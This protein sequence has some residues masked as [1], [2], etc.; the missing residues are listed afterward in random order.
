MAFDRDNLEFQVRFTN[1]TYG[2]KVQNLK[3]EEG[4]RQVPETLM[5]LHIN[6]AILELNIDIEAETNEQVSN[7]VK[8]SDEWL[9]P[10]D[11]LAIKDIIVFSDYEDTVD[12]QTQSALSQGVT[13]RK[14]VSY[15][16]LI[17]PRQPTEDFGINY[18]GTVFTDPTDG[19][20]SS[21]FLIRRDGDT[22]VKFN[23]AT[24][25][26]YYT[27]IHFVKLPD[28]LT[29]GSQNPGI[30]A[31]YQSLIVDRTVYRIA[32]QLGDTGRKLEAER[33]YEKGLQKKNKIILREVT[34]DR[35]I[36]SQNYL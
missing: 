12:D 29:T 34:P 16:A 18:T 11:M 20:P 3:T 28:T 36:L 17:S 32:K 35:L 14:A 4:K 23:R 26:A 15:A 13:L 21:Y 31:T 9:L 33:D 7:T 27:E 19:I 10:T 8:D 25:H 22:L 30:A 5:N 24:D 1:F 6:E 2:G